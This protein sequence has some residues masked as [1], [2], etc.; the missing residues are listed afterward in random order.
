[1]AAHLRFN[2]NN[3]EIEART[4]QGRYTIELLQLNDRATVQYRLLTLR[5]VQM[6]SDE[7]NMQ[8][9]QLKEISR[10]FYQG[11]IA[12]ADYDRV[13]QEIQQELDQLNAA[14]QSF[15]GEQPLP[16]LPKQ[17]LGVSL[18]TP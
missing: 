15:S 7:V 13:T 1:M 3:G 18:V 11:E 12:Q 8:N 10:R 17:R 16:P 14:L 9:Q 5:T 4:S 6:Y 2:K